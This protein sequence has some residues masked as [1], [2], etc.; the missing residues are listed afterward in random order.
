MKA[1]DLLGIVLILLI[2]LQ[3]VS[4]ANADDR[5]SLN[6][7]PGIIDQP[8]AYRGNSRTGNNFSALHCGN[9]CVAHNNGADY[10][11]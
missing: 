10:A 5:F 1:V 7:L 9:H 2:T 11:V 6:S 3:P 8:G 4:D